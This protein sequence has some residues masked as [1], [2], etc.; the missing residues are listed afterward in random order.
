MITFTPVGN[1]HLLPE[2]LRGEIE[3]KR[4]Q[5]VTL[6][7]TLTLLHACGG[8]V[9]V[10][11]PACGVDCCRRCCCCWFSLL[12]LSV[13]V[14]FLVIVIVLVSSCSCS[15]YCSCEGML[16]GDG[17]FLL[18]RVAGPLRVR[19]CLSMLVCY[20]S[21]LR[22]CLCAVVLSCCYAQAP[23]LSSLITSALAQRK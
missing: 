5:V 11:C 15:C 4:K 1:A 17:A 20:W 16:C 14:V 23:M 22:A 12:T 2:S 10:V 3:F 9:V 18:H 19:A 6:A 7:L 13:V 21:D 8:L